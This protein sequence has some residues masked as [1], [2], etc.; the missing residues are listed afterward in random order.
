MEHDKVVMSLSGGADSTTLL[1]YLLN[2]HYEVEGLWFDY[3][4]KH[5]EYEMQAIQS[6]ANHYAIRLNKIDLKTA[7][8]SFKSNLMKNGADIPEGYYAQSNMSQTVVPARN[9]IFISFIAGY[10]WSVGAKYI[11][12]G[13]H[14]GDHE[15]YPDCRPSFLTPMA[16]AIYE[17]T[18]KNVKLIT[19]FV[20][21]TKADVIKTGLKLNVPY[22]LTRTCYKQQ[23]KA[24]GRCGACVERQ[25]A[26]WLNNAQ[27]PIEYE[28]S[29]YWKTVSKVYKDEEGRI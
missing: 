11:S 6:V 22:E 24:C 12:L 15:I 8:Q 1:A 21:F 4:A 5:N 14:Q 20:S 2:K 18:G 17:G 13:V 26:F 7:M 27:D 3:G 16:T 19:P 10:A 9:I 25:E 23:S 29:E 28:D